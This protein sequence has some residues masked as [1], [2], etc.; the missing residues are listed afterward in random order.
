M[1]D[2][3]IMVGAGYAYIPA[4]E[5]A[6]G[7]TWPIWIGTSS[8]KVTISQT[9]FYYRA[10]DSIN[11]YCNIFSLTYGVSPALYYYYYYYIFCFCVCSLWHLICG[12]VKKRNTLCNGSS[13][14]VSTTHL[15]IPPSTKL[16]RHTDWRACS[17]GEIMT[18]KWHR[19]TISD[20]VTLVRLLLQRHSNRVSSQPQSTHILCFWF[21]FALQLI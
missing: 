2:K 13:I 1:F 19:Q 11:S 4:N 15:H 21:L 3:A 7:T 18:S 9:S 17:S 12:T 16:P 20:S 8:W 14:P 5:S 10:C 6:D